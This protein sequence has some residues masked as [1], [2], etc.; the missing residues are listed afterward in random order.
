MIFKLNVR[1][2]V[3]LLLFYQADS[4]LHL[5][6]Y[7]LNVTH[8]KLFYNYLDEFL[9]LLLSRLDTLS[10]LFKK[11]TYFGIVFFGAVAF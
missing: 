9:F 7:L 1:F 10:Q 5:S 3:A 2:A 8:I 6:K 4:F 11:V